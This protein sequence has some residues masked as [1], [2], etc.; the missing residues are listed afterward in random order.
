MAAT[1]N[2]VNI[3][4]VPATGERS[5]GLAPVGMASLPDVRVANA[6]SA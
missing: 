4:T 6:I 1:P 2:N 5:T 3:T